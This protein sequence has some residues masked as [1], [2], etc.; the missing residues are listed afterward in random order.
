M[1]LD[2]LEFFFVFECTDVIH[3]A[4]FV[5]LTQSQTTLAEIANFRLTVVLRQ[6]LV[7]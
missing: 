1:L 5:Q 6:V 7:S 2:Q 4:Q 3:F